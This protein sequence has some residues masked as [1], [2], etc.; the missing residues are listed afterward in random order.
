M[1]NECCQ[2]AV[3]DEKA[4]V[5]KHLV[6]SYL[7]S[8]KNDGIISVLDGLVAA[9]GYD[10]MNFRAACSAANDEAAREERWEVPR[11]SLESQPIE[12]RE[13]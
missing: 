1:P 4:R 6:D 8:L 5:K 9:L 7:R 12:D 2:K 11:T 3:A 13:I 10:A